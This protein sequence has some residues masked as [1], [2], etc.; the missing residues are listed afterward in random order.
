MSSQLPELGSL[1][2][3]IALAEELHFGRAADRLNMTQPTL[4]QKIRKIEA[5][6]GTPLFIRSTRSVEL[7]PSGDAFLPIAREILQKLEQAV[8][9]SKLAAGG[10]SPGGEQLNIGAI[11]PAA[12]RLLPPILRRFRQRFPETRLEVKVLDS[13][14]LLHALERGDMHVGLM[15]PPTNANLIRFQSLITNRFVAVIPKQFA[16]ASRKNLKLSDFAGEKVFTL[17]R[18]E[19]N[20]FRD[21][22]DQ[23]IDAGI[24]PDLTVKV[25]DTIA[26][27]ALA[28]AGL[29]ITFLPDWVEGLIGDDVVIARVEDLSHEISLGVAWR[30]DNPVPGILPFV[31]YAELICKLI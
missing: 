14:E 8:L 27:L 26:A 22:Y 28:S 31:E 1:K 18:F 25:S 10:L 11:D 24:T 5:H 4:S 20:T 21:V 23:V 2:C 29:G 13:S 30:V 12:R 17:N 9:L 7:S 3:F 19:L 15:R 6:V 16:I